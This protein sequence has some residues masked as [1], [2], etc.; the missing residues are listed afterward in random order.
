MGAERSHLARPVSVLVSCATV[1][2][3]GVC[4]LHLHVCVLCACV[5][6]V[7]CCVTVCVVCLSGTCVCVLCVVLLCGVRSYRIFTPH[8]TVVCL[9]KQ[10][11]GA[12]VATLPGVVEC[13]RVAMKR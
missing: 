7:C 6:A 10:H 5:C 13:G 1:W 12:L 11:R 3:I 8:P 9:C 2:V 4:M